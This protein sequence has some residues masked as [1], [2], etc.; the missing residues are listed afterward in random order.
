MTVSSTT[1][2]KLAP[3]AI[4][5]LAVLGALALIVT[6]VMQVVSD[7]PPRGTDE[8]RSQI[9]TEI[10]EGPE[11]GKEAGKLRPETLEVIDRSG[12]DVFAFA[13]LTT[14]DALGIGLQTASGASYS[15]AAPGEQVNSLEAI[16]P[17]TEGTTNYELSVRRS[18]SGNGFEHTLTA[19]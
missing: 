17:A 16:I 2:R 14:T 3:A 7:A 15:V 11:M 10:Q 19:Q 9:I 18:G 4:M 1:R 5:V 12:E 6:F 8:I 13:F